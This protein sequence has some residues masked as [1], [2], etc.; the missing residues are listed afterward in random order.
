[1][2]ASRHDRGDTHL[3][4]PAGQQEVQTADF[5]AGPDRLLL[6]GEIAA[7]Q[8]CAM[9]SLTPTERTAFVLRHMED[10]STEEISTALGI[11]PN[12]ARQAVL[13]RRAKAEEP[14]GSVEG[15]TMKHLSEEEL[16]ELFYSNETPA[17]ATAI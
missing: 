9:R 5:A 8:N 6:S 16:I 2:A 11:A 10:Y 15:E 17:G 7:M 3:R 14:S 13:S 1:M 4:V 12:A